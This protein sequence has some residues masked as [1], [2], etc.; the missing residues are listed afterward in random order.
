MHLHNCMCFQEHL[1]M[2][3][4]S[5][6]AHC[7][8]PPGSGSI[9]KY[10]EGLVRLPGVS[11]RIVCCNQTDLH[12]A[13][14]GCITTGHIVYQ[15]GLC[16]SHKIRYVMIK[17]TLFKSLYIYTY[18]PS[19]HRLEPSIIGWTLS[20]IHQTYSVIHHFEAVAVKL[21]SYNAGSPPSTLHRTTSDIQIKLLS[22][23]G[24]GPRMLA[25]QWDDSAQRSCKCLR[26]GMVSRNLEKSKWDQNLERIESIF[27]LY[28]KMRWKWD[29]SYLRWSLPNIYSQSPGPCPLSLSF[30][31]PAIR[32]CRRT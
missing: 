6:R 7:L 15:I 1:R 27:S 22:E 10:L 20:H 14:E 9:Q 31:T 13:N 28:D 2:L 24:S 5:L 25:R 16:Y 17:Y 21:Q 30:C 11:G 8:P 23:C 18:G 12:F 19:G 4:Q 29:D 32:L 3:L 26:N